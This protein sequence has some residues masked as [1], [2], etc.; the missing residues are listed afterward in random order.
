M[1]EEHGL[2]SLVYG[3][4]SVDKRDMISGLMRDA[5]LEPY[6]VVTKHV[7]PSDLPAWV[8]IAQRRLEATNQDAILVVDPRPHSWRLRDGEAAGRDARAA[9]FARGLDRAA[10]SRG[11]GEDGRTAASKTRVRRRSAAMSAKGDFKKIQSRAEEQGWRVEKRKEYW[12]F[13]PPDQA[14]AP[15]RMAGTPSSSRSL[16]NF[17]ACLRRKGY[18]Q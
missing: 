14:Q 10:L 6:A 11:E 15:C 4:A 8:Y 13:F 5:E 1:P 3:P 17:L 18:I 12:L 2:H 16:E 9:T 7:P